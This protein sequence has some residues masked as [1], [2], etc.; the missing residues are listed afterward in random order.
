[1]SYAAAMVVSGERVPAR[2]LRLFWALMIGSLTLVLL[3]IHNTSH[4]DY[5]CP[6]LNQ[7]VVATDKPN[8]SRATHFTGM[9][10]NAQRPSHSFKTQGKRPKTARW[11][12]FSTAFVTKVSLVTVV[13]RT[14]VP[15]KWLG[16]EA[17]SR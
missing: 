10:P 14:E 7:P 11:F 3:R 4:R 16:L 2:M 6:S 8:I 12:D 1:M 15:A 13:P 9:L 5:S 17:S